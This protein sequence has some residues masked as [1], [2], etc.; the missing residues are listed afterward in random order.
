MKLEYLSKSVDYQGGEPYK[1]RVVLGNSEGVI[2]P[3]FFDPDFIKKESG[4]LFKLALDQIYFVNFPDKAERDKFNQIDEQLEKNKKDGE[5]NKQKVEDVSTLTDV[6][7]SLA[8]TQDGGMEQHAYSKVAAIIKPLAKEKRYTN[9]DI[10]SMPYPFDTNPKWAQGTAT[11]FKFQMQQSEGYTYQ[12]QTV[13]E[14]LQKGVLS[15]ILPKI[16]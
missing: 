15:V 1:T 5:A 2:Y 10:V 8:V 13:A 3:V 14:M 16:E 4:E 7:I 11:I 9:G 12:D 6:L